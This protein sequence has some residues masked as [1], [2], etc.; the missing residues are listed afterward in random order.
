MANPN[1]GSSAFGA[2]Q[3]PTHPEPTMGSSG[4]S[5]R[6][7]VA[8]RGAWVLALVARERRFALVAWPSSWGRSD[9]F[10]ELHARFVRLLLELD[11]V[12]NS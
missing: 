7:E 3:P 12:L 5:P 6:P 9:F 4:F 8:S 10:I 2:Q 1:Y 11:V